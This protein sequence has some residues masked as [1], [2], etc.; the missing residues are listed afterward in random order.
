MGDR[1]PGPYGYVV[2]SLIEFEK[3]IQDVRQTIQGHRRKKE[4]KKWKA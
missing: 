4:A 3:Q 1:I 2:N